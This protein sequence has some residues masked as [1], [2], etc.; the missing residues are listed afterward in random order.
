M[1]AIVQ[2]RYCRPDGLELREVAPPTVRDDE[3]L[4]R[5]RAAS[6]N[7]Y[8]HHFMTGVPYLVRAAAG[9]RRPRNPVPGA[10]LAG[11]VESVGR[12]VTSWRPGDDVF[13]MHRGAFAE[14]ASVPAD[15]LVAKPPTVTFEQAAATPVAGLTALQGL[16]D[17][18]R[19][20][21]G[22]RV[23]VNGASGAV[24]TF[25]VQVARSF[26]TSV[27]AVCST[28]NVAT[29]RRLGAERVI[30]YTAEDFTADGTRYD[31]VFDAVGNRRFADRRRVLRPDGTLVFVGGPK[32]NRVSGPLVGQVVMRMRDRRMVLFLATPVRA[33]LE[34]LAGLLAAGTLVPEIERVY[35]LAEVPAALEYL[36]TGHARGKLVVSV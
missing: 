2:R 18:G 20:R 5:V 24:G 31:L 13:G 30:D 8:D 6:V 33:D 1:R 32:T 25:A 4:V 19:I 34:T 35:P 7:T 11:T 23:L 28:A 29:A 12:A 9:L 26:D 21:P 14:Y 16:R 22:Q 27:T 3:V 15:K 17:K 36:G 10:D